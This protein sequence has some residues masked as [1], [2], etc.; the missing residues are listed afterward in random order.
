MNGILE[1]PFEIRYKNG[2]IH[3]KGLYKND[4]REGTWYVYNPDGTLKNEI[5]YIA[6]MAVNPEIYLKENAYLDSLET[7]GKKLSDPEKTG[8]LW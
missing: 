4:R 2:M 1:G 3:Y 8:T 5:K 7:A 6:G